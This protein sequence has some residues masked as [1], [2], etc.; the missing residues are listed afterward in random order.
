MNYLEEHY[1]EIFKKYSKDE[2]I[3]DVN[4]YKNGNGRLNKVLNH[5][6]EEIIFES[7]APR[8]NKSP[9]EALQNKEDMTFILDYIKT[10]PKF[11]T[12]NEVQNVKSFFRNGGR[13]AQKVANF[14]P[15]NARD[16]YFRYF[17]NNHNINC[18]DTSAGF[19]SRMSS[20]LLNGGGYC[21]FDPNKQLFH[22]LKLYYKFLLENNLI[23]EKQKFG[24]Y[25]CGSE[26]YKSELENKFDVSFT[27]PPYFN[28]EKYSDDNSA[29]TKNYNNYQM[30]IDEFVKPTIENTYLYLKPNGYAM[31]NIKNLTRGKKEPLFDDWFKCFSQIKEFEYVETFEINHQSKKNYTMNTN[32]TKE[33]YKG[34][35]E[36]VMVFKKIK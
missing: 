14:C 13:I 3:K 27:S 11:Y 16:I 1:D 8:G 33:Q 17:P 30:W 29:S 21:G 9:M 12:G 26:I 5:F 36:P 7:Q 35:K 19:D 4:N 34:F 32:Y 2:L 28:L 15:K 23:S 24:L 25:C 31:I 22:Q 10:K 20:V 6:F 18:L